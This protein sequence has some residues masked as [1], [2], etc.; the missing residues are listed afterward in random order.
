MPAAKRSLP[1]AIKEPKVVKAIIGVCYCS[2]CINKGNEIS[3]HIF[4]CLAGVNTPYGNH[5]VLNCIK[6]NIL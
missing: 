1:K 5:S 3:D 2:K 4:L 6:Y